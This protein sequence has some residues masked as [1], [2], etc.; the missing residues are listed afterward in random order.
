MLDCH[1][2]NASL[3]KIQICDVV[4]QRIAELIGHLC[5][6]GT[7]EFKILELKALLACYNVA[8]DQ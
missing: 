6:S 4:K 1:L 8:E 3:P 7:P 5:G 2:A